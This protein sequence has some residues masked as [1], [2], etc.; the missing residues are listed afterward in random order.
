M[1]GRD[2]PGAE[3]EGVIQKRLELDFGIAKHVRIGCAAGLVLGE[4]CAE[5]ALLVFGGKVDRLQLDADHIGNRGA[6][7]QILARRAIRVIVVVFPVL[8]E[9]ADDVEA[10][11]LQQQRG[12]RRVHAAGHADHDLFPTGHLA[13]LRRAS[14]RARIP[15]PA[16]RCRSTNCR[17]HGPAAFRARACARPGAR[18]ILSGRA[19]SAPAPR[20][21]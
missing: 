2:T 5:H 13:L 9:Q 20:G 7:N 1:P 8:H 14:P 17:R 19:G 16:G 3:R 18:Q 12:D 11:A 15:L 4:E 21:T 10:G 6:I